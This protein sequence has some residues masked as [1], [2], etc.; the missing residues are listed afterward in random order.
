MTSRCSSVYGFSSLSMV[1]CRP[2][3]TVSRLTMSFDHVPPVTILP[4]STPIDPVRV[5][6]RATIQLPGADTQQ[7][8]DPATGPMPPTSGLPAAITPRPSP[9]PPHPLHNPPP[10][11]P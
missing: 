7:P 2:N 1:A 6:G 10:Q 8:P 3:A 5:P 11:F 9:I 4:V